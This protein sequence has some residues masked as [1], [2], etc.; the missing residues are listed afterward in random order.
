MAWKT[1]MDKEQSHPVQG[2]RSQSGRML[3]A[4]VC[5]MPRDLEQLTATTR[6][7]VTA[8]PLDR[9]KQEDLRE[10]D[11]SSHTVACEFLP[12]LPLTPLIGRDQEVSHI[13]HILCQ[14]EKRLVTLTGTGGV[15]K[16]HLA[17][18]VARKLLPLFADGV[19]FLSLEAIRKSDH[20][21]VTIAHALGVSA[22]EKH[23][24]LVS[25]IA[26]L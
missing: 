19:T 15:G 17:L 21:L 22:R 3:F 1:I 18:H 23:S 20:V 16:T 7:L 26:F 14:Q 8:E 11:I 6:R 10:N 24:L 13:E 5:F 25:V 9:W 12:P 4:Y 2:A